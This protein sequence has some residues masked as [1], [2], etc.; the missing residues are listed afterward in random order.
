MSEML[1]ALSGASEPPN[2]FVMA[3]RGPETCSRYIDREAL[4][5]RVGTLHTDP[6]YY[7]MAQ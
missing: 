6:V 5:N 7:C 2:V 3:D 4:P 1:G